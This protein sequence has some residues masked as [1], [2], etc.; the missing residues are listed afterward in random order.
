MTFRSIVFCGLVTALASAQDQPAPPSQPF[1]T[2][3]FYKIDD[4]QP[5]VAAK[6]KT[7]YDDI[8]KAISKAGCKRCVYHLWKAYGQADHGYNYVQVSWWPGREVYEKIHKDPGFLAAY[9]KSGKDLEGI[10]KEEV[11]NRMVEIIPGK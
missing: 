8:N 6:L 11:Y 5:E 1:Q 10:V 7:A 9:Q 4:Q 2:V 3:H